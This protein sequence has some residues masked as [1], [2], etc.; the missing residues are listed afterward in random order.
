M[1]QR[2]VPEWIGSSPDA[3]I[4]PRVRLRVWERGIGHCNECGRKIMAGETWELD[5]KTALV[6]GGK[7][8]ETNLQ[9][10]CLWCHRSKTRADIAIK[11]KTSR[12]RTKHLGIK[13]KRSSFKTNRD[14]NW[15]KKISG[16]LIR[17]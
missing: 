4:P 14:G 6:N 11:S 15:K 3:A 10:I 9:I 13:R 16:E 2:S 5:H 12:V 17:R 1:S 7:H 8:R